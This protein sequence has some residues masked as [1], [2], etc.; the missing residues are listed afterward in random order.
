MKAMILAA[1]LGT[2]LYPLTEHFPKPLLPFREKPLI[3]HTLDLL[4]KANIFE[5]VINF[6]HFPDPLK[7]YLKTQKEFEF[8]F[9]DEP[10][11][12]G[13]G[14][15]ILK[16][17][18]YLKEDRFVVINSDVVMQPSISELLKFHLAK[19]SLATM[20][21]RS[22][23]PTER[24]ECLGLNS[25]HQIRQFK[26][27]TIHPRYRRVMFCGLHL[28]EPEI[29]DCFPNKKIFCINSDV[30]AQLIQEKAPV[31]GSLYRGAWLDLGTL[32]LY[33]KYNLKYLTASQKSHFKQML[34]KLAPGVTLP[35]T[36]S[37]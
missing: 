29:F 28:F 10:Q 4:K 24:Y 6:H 18:P 37:R 19:K 8:V 12:L 35:K 14:G 13:T 2:R 3:G 15:G 22:P 25:Q 20:L 34:R 26:V 9:S 23:K 7:K 36:T 11:I 16:A 33:L 17:K 27:K 5:V 32:D 31:F 21:V 30:Y 1:G